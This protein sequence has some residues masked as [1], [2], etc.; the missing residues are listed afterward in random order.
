MSIAQ[1]LSGGPT[2]T[3]AGRIRSLMLKL[4]A[5]LA[6]GV[7]AQCIYTSLFGAPES[8]IHRSVILL[9]CTIVMVILYP[10]RA[11]EGQVWSAPRRWLGLMVDIGMLTVMA[12]AVWRFIDNLEDMEFLVS[13]FDL[14]DKAGA[15]GAMLTV[16]EL[17]RRIFGLP[18]ALVGLIALL[19][20]LFGADLPWIFRHSGFSVEQTVEI[21]WYGFKGVFGF[22]TGIVLTLI[23][24]FIIFGSILQATGAGESLIRI[25]FAVTGRTRGGP[26]H[27]AIAASAMF[28]TMS[29]SVAANVVG[30][31]VLTIPMIKRRGFAPA[32]AGGVESAASSGGQIMPPVMGAAAF[33][34]A[35][36]VGVSY[37]T[38]CL[39]AL[40]PALFFYGSL[41]ASVSLEAAR[42]GIKPLPPEERQKLTRT[43][44]LYSLMFIAPIIAVIVPLVMGRS[45]AAA[46]LAGTLTA[47]VFGFINP[48]V[49]K[50]PVRLVRGLVRGGVAG[51]AIMMAVGSIGVLLGVLDL[52]GIGIKFA[53]AISSIGGDNLFLGLLVAAGSC[54]ILGMGMPTFPAYLIIVLVLGP[55]IK[56][57]GIEAIA[58]HLFVFYFGVLSNITPP[59]AIAAF[60]AAPIAEATPT[61]TAVKAVGLA[62]SGFVIP[63]FF[64]Y[65]TNLLLIDGF[66]VTGLVW[67]MLKLGVALWML[68]TSV[69]GF[70]AARL[71]VVER[72][73][74][75]GIAV[76]LAMTIPA[77]NAA[78]LVGA[79]VFIAL[80]FYRKK[81]IPV[82]GQPAG[83]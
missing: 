24:I 80:R 43:D 52:T 75:A 51:S 40:L 30:T 7:A 19:Y 26:A 38:V 20:C 9:I 60:A 23:L 45:P 15:L 49:R 25:A 16:I 4:S 8:T 3:D 69:V 64:I 62:L 72:L 83:S 28:G 76:L 68:S 66:S 36:L 17:T 74:R 10:T 34:M 70:D 54:L 78:G 18:L 22:P 81:R 61:R 46:G 53:G 31:G 47:F 82:A 50:D 67:V 56:A 5:L 58:I 11:P 55:S 48:E 42:L 29:G 1:S 41:F 33:L 63:F 27:A 12:Y 2:E 79:A 65:D 13:E 14:I 71:T 77:F 44:L 6:F 35:E 32:F 59:V 39:A 57:L 37:L 73:I 21:V